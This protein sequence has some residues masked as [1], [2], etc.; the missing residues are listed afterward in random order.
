MDFLQ[1]TCL[2]IAQNLLGMATHQ[3]R[4]PRPKLLALFRLLLLLSR[5][6][7]EFPLLGYKLLI[8]QWD[9]CSDTP[10]ALPWFN[11]SKNQTSNTLDTCK[12]KFPQTIIQNA[13]EHHQQSPSF[14][15]RLKKRPFR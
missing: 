11:I 3:Q 10:R 7:F 14:S 2:H 12:Y 15:H 6:R 13:H 4:S 1:R 9:Q 8:V 5:P